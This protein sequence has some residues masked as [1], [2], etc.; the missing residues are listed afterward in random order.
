MLTTKENNENHG[1]GLTSVNKVIQKYDGTMSI[2]YNSNI[3]SIS[4]LMY[5]D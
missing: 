4:I 2:D 5:V 3:F 1:I